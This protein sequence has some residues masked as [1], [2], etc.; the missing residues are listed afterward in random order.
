MSAQPAV[1]RDGGPAEGPDHSR[2][3][4]AAH[5]RAGRRPARDDRASFPR[6]S[7]APPR[8][9]ED[10]AR[11][12]GAD[13]RGARLERGD[14][15]HRRRAA[16]AAG[17]RARQRRHR[18]D[19]RR[20]ACRCTSSSRS[21]PSRTR[22]TATPSASRSPTRRTSTASTRSAS[23]AATRSRC[24]SPRARRSRT[25]SAGSPAPQRHSARRSGLSE[26]A[27]FE[28]IDEDELDDLEVDDGISDAPLVRL[29]NSIIFEAA[30]DGA[31]DVHF[32]PQSRRA[33][34]A[35]PDRRRAPRDPAD[36]ASAARSA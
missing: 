27:E 17:G 14:R 23:R 6:R 2:A 1:S 7:S 29:V 10:H 4:L 22:S 3:D 34:R 28:V 36:P 12:A 24:A 20:V 30:E 26:V 16:R 19:G 9:G 25:S 5:G 32:D 31:S 11:R 15:A 21:T 8:E 33:R 13:R 35:L 18:P